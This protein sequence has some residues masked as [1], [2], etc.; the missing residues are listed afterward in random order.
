[1][2]ANGCRRSVSLGVS[3]GLL[4]IGFLVLAGA[5]ARGQEADDASAQRPVGPRAEVTRAFH[6]DVSPPLWLIPPVPAARPRPDYEPKRLPR[7]SVGRRL[8][9][10]ALQAPVP[11]AL[12]PAVMLNVDGVGQGFS[13]PAGTFS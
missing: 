11:A 1:M 2:S 10:T 3:R 4:S 7:P 9:D 6:H 12:A 5:G 8:R 13:G